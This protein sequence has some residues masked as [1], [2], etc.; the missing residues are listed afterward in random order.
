M[1]YCQLRG[2]GIMRVL[3]ILKSEFENS[4]HTSILNY[5][6]ANKVIVN[7]HCADGYCGMCHSVL[8]AGQIQTSDKA[9][10]YTPKN[11]F[12]ICCSKPVSDI[13]IEL[14]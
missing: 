7:F 2:L 11:E 1:R 14:Y 10:G 6:I 9:I 12:L 5:L 3:N 4:Q 13:T 8:R